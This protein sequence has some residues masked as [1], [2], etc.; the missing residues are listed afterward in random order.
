MRRKDEANKGRGGTGSSG[1]RGGLGGLVTHE[2]LYVARVKG[3][4]DSVGTAVALFPRL[5]YKEE[6]D[7]DKVC[8][9]LVSWGPTFGS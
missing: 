8:D 7:P 2:E 9:S 1:S 5:K 6:S 3:G 4:G